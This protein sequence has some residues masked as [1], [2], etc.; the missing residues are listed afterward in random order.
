MRRVYDAGADR[1]VCRLA[2]VVPQL[3]DTVTRGAAD[4]IRLAAARSMTDV[5]EEG[6]KGCAESTRRGRSRRGD[7][8][9]EST[10][11]VCCRYHRG[12]CCTQPFG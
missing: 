12:G 6:K 4:S 11:R 8:G 3:V 7:E 2:R 9:D 5:Y 10:F 1:Q